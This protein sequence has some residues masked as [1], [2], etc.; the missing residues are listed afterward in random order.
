MGEEL[1][2]ESL[3]ESAMESVL[4]TVSLEELVMVLLEELAMGLLPTVLSVTVSAT[5]LL[6]E[7]AMELESDTA[8]LEESATELALEECSTDTLATT[9]LPSSTLPS[10]VEY[11]ELSKNG[12]KKILIGHKLPKLDSNLI[13][14]LSIEINITLTKKKS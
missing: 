12:I 11:L 9:E 5:A 8:S 14:I 7:S 1:V 13:S 3:E 10:L 2:M 6:E 4:D